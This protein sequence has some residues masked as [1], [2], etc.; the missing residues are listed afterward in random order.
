MM[1]IIG[2]SD[3]REGYRLVDIDNNKVRFNSDVVIDE[4]VG[5]FR[6]SLEFKFTEQLVVAK[7]LGV[8]LQVA[9][10]KGGV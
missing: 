6:T 4:E 10:P 9:A 8:K 1:M 3:N 2:Y 7:D 5:L